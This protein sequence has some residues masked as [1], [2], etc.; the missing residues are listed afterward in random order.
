[1]LAVRLVESKVASLVERK[2][3]LLVV[4]SVV[5]LV[6]KMDS[7]TAAMLARKRVDWK[8]VQ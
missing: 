7:L 4:M 3:H 2:G 1:M 6:E 8:A 5:S